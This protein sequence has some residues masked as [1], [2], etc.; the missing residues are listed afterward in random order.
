METSR[1]KSK[2][3]IIPW[4]WG[5]SIIKLVPF[6]IHMCLQVYHERKAINPIPVILQSHLI[7]LVIK[8]NIQTGLL[9]NRFHN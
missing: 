3:D 6:A 1:A 4:L 7:C 2:T 5:I 9:P 8:V